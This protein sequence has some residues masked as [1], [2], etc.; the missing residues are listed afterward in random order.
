MRPL[1]TRTRLSAR[2][3]AIAE[4]SSDKNN[5]AMVE[6]FRNERSN[7][8]L[9][10]NQTTHT[11]LTC[12]HGSPR[13]IVTFAS[14]CAARNYCLDSNFGDSVR[15]LPLFQRTFWLWKIL[16]TSK[17]TIKFWMVQSMQCCVLP[18]SS[19]AAVSENQNRSDYVPIC[20]SKSCL[21][22]GSRF[23]VIIKMSRWGSRSMSV[24]LLNRSTED[25]YQASNAWIGWIAASN[26]F[27]VGRWRFGK[28]TN[29]GRFLPVWSHTSYVLYS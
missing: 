4:N 14:G 11:L 12:R 15:S 1:K 16:I 29:T 3:A 27:L 9:N 10:S 18:V 26:L 28:K 13:K 23:G 17:Q 21:E 22:N 7:V 24:S 19:A 25:G 8:I 20:K 2:L 5:H 6:S